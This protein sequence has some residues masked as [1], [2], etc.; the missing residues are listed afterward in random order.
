M[1]ISS[2]ENFT[3]FND[4]EIFFIFLDFLN[5]KQKVENCE[6][7]T[8]EEIKRI[9]TLLLKNIQNEF[10][11]KETCIFSFDNEL[12]IHESD[13]GDTAVEILSALQFKIKYSDN[14]SLENYD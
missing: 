3:N 5:G 13:I 2:L 1:D 6:N 10:V 8:L 9:L 14:A 12:I 4:C 11:I 7:Q